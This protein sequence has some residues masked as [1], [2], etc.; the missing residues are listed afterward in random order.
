MEEKVEKNFKCEI[1]EKDFSRKGYLNKHKTR[2]HTE[3]KQFICNVCCSSF[4]LQH[5][6][7]SHISNY[8]QKGQRKFKCDSCGKSL[9]S[10]HNLKNHIK[11]IHEGQRNNNC[12][13]CS[14]T[15]SVYMKNHIRIQ[16]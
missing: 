13:S 16:M 12:D 2:V 7:N 15:T 11:N 8:H 14:F 1:C 6:L 3:D 9:T 10:S 4:T 5:K